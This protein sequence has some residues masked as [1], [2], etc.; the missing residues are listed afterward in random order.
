MNSPHN[1]TG[2]IL[3]REKLEKI[4]KVVK[5]NDS[6]WVFS[7][8]PYCRTVHNEEFT[9]IASIPGMQERTIMVDCVSKTYAMTGWR[10]GYASNMKLA[11]H[12]SR[13]ITN[14]DS[15]AAHPNQ[16]A[17]LA[18][19]TVPQQES[20]EMM[21]S[22][23]RRRDIIVDGLNRTPGINCLKPGG[24]FYAWPNV[25]DA[26]K[27]VNARDSEEFRKRLLNE[28]GVAALSD[29]HFGHRNAGEGQHIR[30]SYATSEKNIREG[31]ERIRGFIEEN[32]V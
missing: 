1:P 30:L 11:P 23:T 8:E 18:A 16:Y 12:L 28:A 9:S 31:L 22:Y 20:H 32:T 7:D 24:A 21:R 29:I 15:C 14:T 2:G 13:W 3:G 10:I 26:C 17:A 4:S 6:L 25:T 5:N 27:L 19:I